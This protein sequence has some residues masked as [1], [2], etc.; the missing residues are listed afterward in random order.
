MFTINFEIAA[1]NSGRENKF[2]F[3][4]YIFQNCILLKL[5]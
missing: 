4:T 1:L 3:A 2:V 5:I